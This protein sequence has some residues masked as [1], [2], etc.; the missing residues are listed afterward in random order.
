MVTD[1]G[2]DWWS[3]YHA[4]VG[5]TDKCRHYVELGYDK[6]QASRSFTNFIMTKNKLVSYSTANGEILSDPFA[7]SAISA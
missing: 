2:I 5:Q 7:E 3:K 6:I 4:S 1:E